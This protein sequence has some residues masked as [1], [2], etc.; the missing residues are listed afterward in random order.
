MKLKFYKLQLF[1]FSI[2]I[3]QALGQSLFDDHIKKAERGDIRSIR[4]MAFVNTVEKK[5]VEAFNWLKK[6][7][8]LGDAHSQYGVGLSYEEG[9]G[10]EKNMAEAVKWYRKA[11][12]Q[13]FPSALTALAD[14]YKAGNGLDKDFDASK[15]LYEKA[16]LLGDAGGKSGLGG[17]LILKEIEKKD[18]GEPYDFAHALK[19]IKEASVSG[20]KRGHRYLGLSFNFGIGVPQD[21]REA[22]NWYTKAAEAGDDKCFM[23]LST[24]S[25]KLDHYFE[26]YKWANIAAINDKTNEASAAKQRLEVF[27]TGGLLADAQAAS[28]K[29]LIKFRPNRF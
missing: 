19:L 6:A 8:T 27:L 13:D 7:A 22:I 10:V 29:W 24:C 17:L 18:N 5:P 11:A 21:Y 4:Y 26:A 3:V 16:V 20:D 25:E 1:V 9:D 23:E 12:D 15:K 2:L 28:R 14:C